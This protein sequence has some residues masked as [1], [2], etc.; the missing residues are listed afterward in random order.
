MAQPYVP[1]AEPEFFAG[2]Q[3]MEQI[4]TLVARAQFM[5]ENV[6]VSWR[7][8]PFK[9][10]A[11]VFAVTAL[12]EIAT[13]DG[14]NVKPRR[15]RTTVC[16]EKIALRK[17]QKIGA[18]RAIGI[19]V[20]G[21]VNKQK[22][23]EVTFAATPTLHPCVNCQVM[24]DGHPL[25]SPDTLVITAGLEVNTYQVHEYEKLRELYMEQD[26]AGLEDEAVVRNLDNWQKR[27][28]KYDQLAVAELNYLDAERR[29]V[30]ALAKTALL[31]A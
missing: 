15:S 11:S 29:S 7:D 28:D 1:E 23:K 21:T 24:F 16:A 22:I 3:F 30:S 13:A 10:G 17:V 6:A 19:A 12:F 20:A 2:H 27:V 4:P 26:L 8:D 31:V 5:A 18:T 9:V 14:A 25:I